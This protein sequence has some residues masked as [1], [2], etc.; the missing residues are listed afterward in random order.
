MENNQ[1]PN[2]PQFTPETI[3]DFHGLNPDF[4]LHMAVSNSVNSAAYPEP[5]ILNVA[6]LEAIVAGDLTDLAKQ[7]IAEVVS[8]DR[9]GLHDETSLKAAIARDKFEIIWQF[10]KKKRP[11]LAVLALG[12]PACPGCGLEYTF[13]DIA[14]MRK[15]MR[16]DAKEAKENGV[17]LIPVDESALPGAFEEEVFDATKV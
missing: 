5:Y 15:K 8:R 14:D 17:D 12:R 4:I 11:T 6:S 3:E 10:I 13:H 16:K 1:K 2:Y 7:Q 9:P